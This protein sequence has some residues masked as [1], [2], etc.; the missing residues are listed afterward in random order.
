MLSKPLTEYR[1]TE[2]GKLEASSVNKHVIKNLDAPLEKKMISL[3]TVTSAA[4]LPLQVPFMKALTEEIENETEHIAEI[5]K[6]NK[7]IEEVRNLSAVIS[8]QQKILEQLG[9]CSS[10]DK[11]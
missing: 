2:L 11:K 6:Q 4:G 5:C 1:L 9:Y 8:T 3:Q 7:L 10:S